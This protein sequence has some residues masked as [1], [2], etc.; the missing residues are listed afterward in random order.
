MI[1]VSN[2]IIAIYITNMCV[3]QN[4]GRVW[5]ER[6]NAILLGVGSEV[7]IIIK[8]GFRLSMS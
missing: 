3:L 6:P 5:V 2:V 1:I 4:W 8:F 7:R